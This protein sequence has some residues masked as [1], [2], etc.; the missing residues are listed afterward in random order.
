MRSQLDVRL[1][2]QTPVI[3]HTPP[4]VHSLAAAEE[5]IQLANAYGVCDGYPLAESQ[6][7]TL[8]NGLGERRDGSWA[9]T[10][11]ADFG[12]R[13]GTGK[14]DKIAARELAGLLLYGEKLIIH[15]AHEFPTANESFLRLVAVFEAWDDLRRKVSRIRY[16]NGEQGIELRSGQRLKYRA[17]TGGSGRG[18][19]KADLVV[20][21][22]AQH[23]GREHIA[24]SGPAK[25]ANPN[26]QTWYAGSGGLTTSNVAWEVRRAALSRTGGRLAYTEMTG[27]DVSYVD[28][29]IST[30]RPDA[31]DRD[32]WYRAMP[33]LGRWV[34]E[35]GMEALYDELGPDLFARECLCVWDPEPGQSDGAIDVAAWGDIADGPRPGYEGSLPLDATVRI[36][37]DAPPDRKSATFASAGVRAD[38]LL[39]VQDRLHLRPTQTDDQSLK[40]R[41]VD[42]ALKL[43][44]GHKTS[45][46]LPPSS[47]ARAWKADLL[48]AGVT[49]DEMSPAEYA[50]ACGRITNAIDDGAL[51][52]RDQP[53]MNNAVAGLAARAAG[54]V[55]TWSRRNSSSNIAPFVAATCA[56]GR[57]PVHVPKAGLFLAVT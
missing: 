22:E 1:G 45:L 51:R 17:R 30:V 55:E 41:V 3:L 53:S 38:G 18:F 2:S 23:L 14:N 48:A 7:I 33:G 11:I 4:D 20:Y 43:T 47:P 31:S 52:H 54:D 27:E 13:Q 9:A 26:A 39:H 49:L 25:L 12:P 24:A 16:A 44:A 19:A 50:E 6:E 15:T 29:K 40:D 28:G 32:V 42:A 57:V 35:E 5:A 37:L 46:I 36:A 10:R 34:T 21:D 8:R 56:L